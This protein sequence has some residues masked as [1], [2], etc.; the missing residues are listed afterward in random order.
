[1]A[2]F[3]KEV[4]IPGTGPTPQKG[5]HVTVSADLVRR[6]SG[7]AGSSNARTQGPTRRFIWRV[8][9]SRGSKGGEGGGS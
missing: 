3:T 4:L 7:R 8:A 9:S 2:T 6:G 1:M 5:Q